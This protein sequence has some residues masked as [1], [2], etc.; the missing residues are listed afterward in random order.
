[1]DQRVVHRRVIQQRAMRQQVSLDL[2]RRFDP[3]AVSPLTRDR[4]TY[5]FFKRVL[6]VAGAA[7]A[8]VTLSPLMAL[9]G[10]LIVLDSGWPAIFA[11]ERVGA[12]RWTRGGFAYWR[13]TSFIC[14]KFRTMV[15]NADPHVHRVFVQA[16]IRNDQESMAAVQ[17]LCGEAGSEP[18]SSFAQD[19]IRGDDGR[20][21]AAQREESQLRK[22]AHDPRV[23]RLGRFLRRSSLDEL[24]QLWNVLR[25][26]MSLVGPRPSIPYEVDEYEP[27]HRQRLKAKPG[28]TGLWQVTARSSADFDE[29]VRLDIQYIEHQSLWLDLKMLLKTPRAVLSGKGAV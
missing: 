24:P 3:L 15:Q 2:L 28:L 11:Q 1:V 9:I 7:L 22:L 14:Y 26:D 5:Y 10:L 16:F 4:T 17:R 27:W 29:M 13:R 20:T 19:F 18:G 21:A 8:L 23:T 25:G 6:D 12:R